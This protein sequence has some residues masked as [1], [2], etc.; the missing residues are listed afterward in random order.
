MRPDSR[1]RYSTEPPDEDGRKYIVEFSSRNSKGTVVP[2]HASV[3]WRIEDRNG[4]IVDE[5]SLGFEAVMHEGGVTSF[6]VLSRNLNPFGSQSDVPGRLVPDDLASSKS[7]NVL[8]TQ[9]VFEESQNAIVDWQKNARGYSLV[10]RSC[11]Q[12]VA[13]VARVVGIEED[14]PLLE[15]PQSYVGRLIRRTEL[16]KSADLLGFL[17]F[18][19]AKKEA[20]MSFSTKDTSLYGTAHEAL[21][22]AA[23]IKTD[24]SNSICKKLDNAELKKL[25]EFEFDSLSTEQKELFR[26]HLK[27]AFVESPALKRLPR[28]QQEEVMRQLFEGLRSSVSIQP[29][30][31]NQ[32]DAQAAVKVMLRFSKLSAQ[33]NNRLAKKRAKTNEQAKLTNLQVQE[34]QKV[35]EYE[36]FIESVGAVVGPLSE[37]SSTLQAAGILKGE[38]VKQLNFAISK[39][40][41]MLNVMDKVNK[42]NAMRTIGSATAGDYMGAVS[43]VAGLIFGGKT[44][45]AASRHAQVMEALGVVLK[46]QKAIIENQIRIIDKLDELE[47]RL[48]RFQGESRRSFQKTFEK[49]E[50]LQYLALLN[51]QANREIVLDDHR[52]AI[53]ERNTIAQLID[54]D[55]APTDEWLSLRKRLTNLTAG[56]LD[57]SK[58]KVPD[59]YLLPN[60]SKDVYNVAAKVDQK[61]VTRFKDWESHVFVPLLERLGVDPLDSTTFKVPKELG[62]LPSPTSVVVQVPSSSETIPILTARIINVELAQELTDVSLFYSGKFQAKTSKEQARK[63][64]ILKGLR[65]LLHQGLIQQRLVTGA[66]RCLNEE[67]VESGDIHSFET[68]RLLRAN[69][70]FAVNA[71]RYY[72]AQQASK[73]PR[74]TLRALDQLLANELY[75]QYPMLLRSLLA[76]NGKQFPFDLR[77]EKEDGWQVRVEYAARKNPSLLAASET[78]VFEQRLL[79][80]RDERD[81]AV[82]V[83]FPSAQDLRHGS[84]SATDDLN[85]IV[86]ALLLVE[87]EL[88]LQEQVFEQLKV[89]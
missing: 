43:A 32:V 58:P 12:F 51:L 42:L 34:L 5:R 2:G 13:S 10:D 8:V 7:L 18:E 28:E 40:H 49:L 89:R 48:A 73:A 37:L 81:F 29:A 21:E 53:G 75:R 44:D 50:A 52:K 88:E 71:I 78:D 33:L 23:S 24:V 66:V 14:T 56:L 45:P 68:R 46:N 47:A 85:R 35:S 63:I 80:E 69:P 6:Q 54:L 79:D 3:S 19:A 70:I 65:V 60:F 83:A 59:A 64:L 87:Q 16:S 62:E 67:L 20:I 9:D 4:I 26:S 57:K 82:K 39:T 31:V 15:F 84:L 41:A 1:A 27:D 61:T 77:Y 86:R 72:C 30:D 17:D 36:D 55:E 25:L 38:R 22:S 11:T 74:F 76:D